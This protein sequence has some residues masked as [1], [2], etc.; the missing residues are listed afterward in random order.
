MRRFGFVPARMASSRFPGKPLFQIA[1]MPLVE[2]CYRRARLYEG[3]DGLWVCTCD[4]E[5]RRWAEKI[6]APVVMTSDRH[7][8]ALDR[9]GEAAARCGAGLA[10]DDVVV[11]VQG[12]EPMLHPEMI[13]A[14]VAPFEKSADV[15]VTVLGVPVESEEIFRDPNTCKIVHNLEGDVLYLSRTPV[16]YTKTW[17]PAVTPLRIFGIFAFR[18]H[19]LKRFNALEESPL[20]KQEALDSL[21][22]MDNGL[23][24]RVA[25]YGGSRAYS[26]DSPGDAALV[27]SAIR[28]DKYWSRYGR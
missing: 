8:R 3:W 11:C 1:G 18:W 24:Q 26:V 27:E 25:V 6:E 15:H 23:K 17:P 4:E 2:H 9:V 16:P 14:L 5:I 12:D 28:A 7:T 19:M 10:A 22:L 13:D 21:R 20:E